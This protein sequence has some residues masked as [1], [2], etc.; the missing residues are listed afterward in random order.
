MLG[1]AELWDPRLAPAPNNQTFNQTFDAKLSVL[2]A[3][4]KLA[5]LD[6][7]CMHV[8]TIRPLPGTTL[9]SQHASAVLRGDAVVRLS[10]QRARFPE[11][12]RLDG[13]LCVCGVDNSTPS[14]SA[15]WAELL[16]DDWDGS[17][18]GARG[19][20]CPLRQCIQTRAIGWPRQPP[21]LLGEIL[22]KP[23]CV[24]PDLRLVQITIF[25][26]P[27]CPQCSLFQTLAKK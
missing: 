22:L 13:L 17:R 12:V 16:S 5:R 1:F 26:G 14:F 27:I 6:A 2:M 3:D 20:P 10:P 9:H 7:A 11:D 25:L 24:A 21:L 18:G 8:V 23:A 4:A 19:S 15:D